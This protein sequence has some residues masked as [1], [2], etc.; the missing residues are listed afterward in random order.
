MIE[1]AMEYLNAVELSGEKRKYA[2]WCS[3]PA[4]PGQDIDFIDA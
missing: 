3:R 4:G 1:H 2:R